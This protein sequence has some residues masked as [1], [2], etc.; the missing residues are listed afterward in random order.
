MLVQHGKTSTAPGKDK[1]DLG[2]LSD[3]EFGHT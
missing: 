1:F 2:S 3:H